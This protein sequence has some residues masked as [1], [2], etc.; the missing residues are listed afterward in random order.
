MMLGLQRKE[1][2]SNQPLNYF[3]SI[4]TYVTTIPQRHKRTGRRT[5]DGQQQPTTLFVAWRGKN[6][7]QCAYFDGRMHSGTM[8]T[9][10]VVPR[11]CP[12]SVDVSAELASR[13][14][15]EVCQPAA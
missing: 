6:V 7:F 4:L 3:R 11:W 2:R 5:T 10:L 13:R 8:G 1:A 14:A 9:R 15:V 12:R